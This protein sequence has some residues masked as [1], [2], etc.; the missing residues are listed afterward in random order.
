MFLENHVLQ[1]ISCFK[2]ASVFNRIDLQLSLSQV[3]CHFLLVFHQFVV[4]VVGFILHV[5]SFYMVLLYGEY[6][7]EQRLKGD[8]TSA[9]QLIVKTLIRVLK[10]PS[11]AITRSQC[12]FGLFALVK[13]FLY[14]KVIRKIRFF[15]KQITSI[16]WFHKYLF[17]NKIVK[18]EWLFHC[19]SGPIRKHEL[20][21]PCSVSLSDNYVIVKLCSRNIKE[22]A[23]PVISDEKCICYIL[24]STLYNPLMHNIF[25]D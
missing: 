22:G 17:H 14:Q 16:Q 6:C 1:V 3:R 21:L 13:V 8:F 10:L 19:N 9:G 7:S 2:V 4:V 12:L 24:L 18:M 23:T 15:F 5:L 20:P 11:T 25:C